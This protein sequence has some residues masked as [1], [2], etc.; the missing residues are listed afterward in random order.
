MPF[1]TKQFDTVQPVTAYSN[2]TRHV[3]FIRHSDLSD[4]ECCHDEVIDK[5]YID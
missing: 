1:Y 3:K 4:G 2:L 5:M